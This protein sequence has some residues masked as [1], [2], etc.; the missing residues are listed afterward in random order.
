MNDIQCPV[1]FMSVN[2][3]KVRIT[4]LFVLVLTIVYLFTGFWP[5]V[6]FLTADFFLRAFNY[7]KYSPL[8]LL[9]GFAVRLFKLPNKIVEQGPK[10]FAAKIGLIFFVIIT[11]FSWLHLLI[12]S[13]VL[14]IVICT[15]AFLESFVGFCAGCYVYSFYIK[16]FKKK[17]LV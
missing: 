9:S 10:R 12:A 4:A 5:I 15:F 8:G 17:E 16:L 13:T 1:D 2:E 7:G 14:A 3:N 6:L 11:G